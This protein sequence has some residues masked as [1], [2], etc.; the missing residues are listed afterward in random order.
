MVA[1]RVEAHRRRLPQRPAQ[2]RPGPVAAQLARRPG[3]LC[4]ASST[5]ARGR[6]SS[7]SAST[8]SDSIPPLDGEIEGARRLGEAEGQVGAGVAALPREPERLSRASPTGSGRPAPTSC[9]TDRTRELAAGQRGCRGSAPRATAA[10]WRALTPEA[11]EHELVAA[12]EPNIA[13]GASSVWADLGQAPL[14]TRPRASRR[15]RR[16]D[17]GSRSPDTSVDAIAEW[18]ARPGWRADRAVLGALDEVDEQGRSS[19]VGRAA[20]TAVY[21]PWLDAA[22]KALQAAVGPDGERRHLRRRRLRRRRRRARSSCSSTGSA[23]TSPTCSP[24]G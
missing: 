1:A 8:T 5:T 23:S 20:L 15:G 10:I 19:A 9:F 16:R 4:A 12:R 17:V 14:A 7:S 24:I 11:R 13:I 21:R 3:R 6:R 2:S 22:A 18:Y